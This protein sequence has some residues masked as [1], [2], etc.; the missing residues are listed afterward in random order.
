MPRSG[1]LNIRGDDKDNQL[2]RSLRRGT[3][4]RI[5]SPMRISVRSV[6]GKVFVFGGLFCGVGLTGCMPVNGPSSQDIKAH[7]N[8]SSASL[9]YN[10]VQLTPTVVSVLAK[11]LPRLRNVFADKSAP[12][13]IRFGIGDVVSVTI[14]ES[15]AG[16]L[17]IPAEAAARPG[18][19]ITL[20]NQQVD[21]KG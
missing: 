18:N 17:F 15:V 1:C 13:D 14:F 21:S 11:N 3:E 9:P 16:G 7:T 6:L 20:P 8:V 2:V 19:F 5:N 12:K 4:T 10:L